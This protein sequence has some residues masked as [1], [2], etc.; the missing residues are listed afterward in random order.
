M[1]F[2]SCISNGNQNKSQS[3][4]IIVHNEINIPRTH[5]GISL[6]S[7]LSDVKRAIEASGEWVVD[8]D[9]DKEHNIIVFEFEE[10]GPLAK[11][12]YYKFRVELFDGKVDIIEIIPGKNQIEIIEMIKGKYPFI[13][14]K[15]D[16]FSWI[17]MAYTRQ[18][19]CFDGMTE[20]AFPIERNRVLNHHVYYRDVALIKKKKEF[21][22]KVEREKETEKKKYAEQ[23]YDNY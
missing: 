13:E 14:R 11:S 7:S 16:E 15:A 10:I 23:E 2:F 19:V 20:I 3:D 21:W 9:E 17:T 8:I 22:E 6:G 5:S 12:K 18:L 1:S 4:E